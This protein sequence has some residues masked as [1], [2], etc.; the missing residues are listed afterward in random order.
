MVCSFDQERIRSCVDMGSA[1]RLVDRRSDAEVRVDLVWG[2]VSLGLSPCSTASPPVRN[3][4]GIVVVSRLAANGGR[5][6]ID[7]DGNRCDAF[8]Q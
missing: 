2:P 3:T 5:R 6:G 8:Q 4:I 7:S 1:Q